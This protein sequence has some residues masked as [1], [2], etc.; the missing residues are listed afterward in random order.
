[1]LPYT[2]S[3]ELFISSGQA[4]LRE[5]ERTVRGTFVKGLNDSDIAL[6]D[7]FEGDVRRPISQEL[8]SW[9]LTLS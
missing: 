4:D 8:T 2:K 9:Y 5:E 3:K 1:M 6:L 7:L